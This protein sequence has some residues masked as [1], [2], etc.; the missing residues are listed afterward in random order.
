M[1]DVKTQFFPQFL[2][3]KISHARMSQLCE[4]S[5]ILAVICLPLKHWPHPVLSSS[6]HLLQLLLSSFFLHISS[7]GREQAKTG[8]PT[9]RLD[10]YYWWN[11][12]KLRQ[13]D[14]HFAPIW[15]RQRS[16][17]MRR[18]PTEQ[19]AELENLSNGRFRGDGD[20]TGRG[21]L[22]PTLPSLPVKKNA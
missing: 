19:V 20:R 18:R 8:T 11:C 2:T 9:G 13:F 5:M 1:Y 15:V 22:G 7:Q 21:K 14:L 17:Q 16:S 6:S 3:F 12:W 10:L 4:Q